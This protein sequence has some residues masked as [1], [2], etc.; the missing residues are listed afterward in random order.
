MPVGGAGCPFYI[1][2]QIERPEKAHTALVGHVCRKECTHNLDPADKNEKVA[3]GCQQWPCSRPEPGGKG[4]HPEK[5]ST[6]PHGI[7]TN[8]F[9]KRTHPHNPPECYDPEECLAF[10]FSSEKGRDKWTR[11]LFPLL[12][13]ISVGKLAEK[14][15]TSA[16]NGQVQEKGKVSNGKGVETCACY[17]S[18][19]E[20]AQGGPI[21]DVRLKV[22]VLYK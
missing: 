19:A 18:V 8:R 16:D 5:S 2:C 20:A 11:H 3:A 9:K 17:K 4:G 7:R 10:W 1:E 22:G 14:W 6:P 15:D 21:L 12:A 13:Q